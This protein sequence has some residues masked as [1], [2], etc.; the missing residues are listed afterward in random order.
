MADNKQ[1]SSSSSAKKILEFSIAICAWTAIVF[2]AYLT[3]G[4][5]GNLFSYFTILTNLLIAI[6]VTAIL[7]LPNNFVGIFF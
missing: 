5:M 3:T 2:Q 1:T 4:T 7:L 6:C